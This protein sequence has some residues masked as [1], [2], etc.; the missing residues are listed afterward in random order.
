MR[1]T[2]HSDDAV[3][4][5]MYAASLWDS[6]RLASIREIA[7]A[8]GVSVNHLMKVVQRLGQEGLLHRQRGRHRGL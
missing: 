2:Q 1:L 7:E 6:G 3:R 4:V 8:F 5:L